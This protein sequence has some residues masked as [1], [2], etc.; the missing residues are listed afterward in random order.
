MLSELPSEIISH[1][2]IYLPSLSELTRLSL[3]CRRLYKIIKGQES[4]L[5]R[6]FVQQKFPTI[7]I[8]PFWKDAACALT[9][10][11]RALDRLGVVGRFVSPPETAINIGHHG[12][13]RRDNP[14]LGYRPPIDSYETWNGGSWAER[15]EVLTWGAG[16]RLV[17]RIKQSGGR[18]REDWV[19]FNDID[20]VSSYD[21]ICGVHL[22]EPE[23]GSKAADTENV[24][25][26]RV[27]GE[28]VRLA[29]SPGDATH[30]YKQ[31]FLTGGLELAAT[32]LSDGAHPLLLAQ[33]DNKSLALYSTA[34]DSEEVEPLAWIR[35]DT[36]SLARSRYSKLVSSS[37]IAIATKETE[38]SLVVSTV[39]TDGISPIRDFAVN[40]LDPEGPNGRPPFANASS[41]APL[42]SHRV[43]GAPG[44]VF[45][46]A[47][48]DRVVRYVRRLLLSGDA[49][50]PNIDSGYMMFALR[51]HTKRHIETLRTTIL[52]T[53]CSHLHT[54]GSS[55]DQVGMLL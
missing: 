55:S 53:A 38:S 45:L 18:T 8:P 23:Y 15:K 29:L 10:R 52:Y 43:A 2:A 27:R 3:T 39:S 36:F 32:D 25:F 46:T 22:L 7:E 19:L 34:V 37:R 24:I 14:T 42:N 4:S 6:A 48:G 20:H 1:I 30:V 17:M 44:D 16:H 5:F 31:K 49:H 11:S 13:T 51:I 28:I 33:F 47:W 9:S 54:T 26:G 12:E 41:I 50:S 40:F 21:D 35:D